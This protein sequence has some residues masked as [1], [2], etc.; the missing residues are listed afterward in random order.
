MGND[1]LL[2]KVKPIFGSLLKE[3]K[4]KGAIKCTLCWITQTIMHDGGDPHQ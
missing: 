2:M 1:I 4:T 3:A